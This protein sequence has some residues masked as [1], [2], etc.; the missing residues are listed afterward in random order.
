MESTRLTMPWSGP[1]ITS[2]VPPYPRRRFAG[3]TVRGRD[4]LEVGGYD[5]YVSGTYLIT[6]ADR[7]GG[8]LAGVRRVLNGRL[9]GFAGV[10]LLPFFTPY[11]GA[12][13][14]FDA[15]DHGSVDPR[16]GTWDDVRAL[17]GDGYDVVADL[18]VNHMSAASAE[19]T[20]W[21]A[22]GADSPYDGLFLTYADVFPDGATEADITAF[23]RP[24][25]GLPFT[26]YR[27]GDGT[28][29]LMW[30]TFMPSQIDIN[31][32][33][34]A[35][36]AYLETILRT[37][38]EAGA[39]MVRLDAVGYVIKT[40]GTDSFMT[41]QTLEYVRE[42]AAVCRSYGLKVLVEVHA[43]YTQQ[44]AVAREVDYVYD[45]ATPALLLHGLRTGT[46]A[47]FAAWE[48][49]RPRNTFTVLDTHDGIG[50]IDAGP[51]GVETPADRDK[52]DKGTVRFVTSELRNVT[53]RTVP[54]SHSLPGLITQEDMAALFT[55]IDANSRGVSGAASVTPAWFALPHQA[56]TTYYEALGRD[57]AAY[58][59]ARAVQF[60]LPGIPQVY[61]VGLLAGANDLALWHATG[62]GREV[63]R[64]RYDETEIDA[65][66]ERDIVQALFGL[67]ALRESPVFDGEYGFRVLGEGDAEFRWWAGE[68]T[69]TLVVDVGVKSTVVTHVRA[70]R[71]TTYSGVADLARLGRA[72][73]GR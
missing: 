11:D 72:R 55:W 45:F 4:D 30:T 61:Y 39:G 17:A 29:H 66:L 65:A 49:V 43:H 64:H 47:P 3:L 68:E 19:F 36:R 18:I 12:D 31:V 25:P 46:L 33:S 6:Y 57:D 35:G 67:M 69:C 56:N 52:R 9:R 27:A 22:R 41:P 71:T 28:R 73:L 60:F 50:I 37:L 14:G 23:Y 62:Q 42:L 8:D 7:L 48:G 63:N 5:A 16:L 54:L 13:A 1:L 34:G 58:L 70:G 21:L 38:A 51:L 10:H 32:R 2:R 26:S 20:D 44:L 59:L 40:P 15:V 24:R 53:K